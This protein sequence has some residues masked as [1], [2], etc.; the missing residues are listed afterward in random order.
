MSAEAVITT[1]GRGPDLVM[2]HGWAMNSNCWGELGER[3]SGSFRLHLVDLPGHGRSRDGGHWKLGPVVAQIRAQT[4]PA[5]WLGWSLGGFVA[6]RAALDFPSAVH[7]LILLSTNPCFVAS[8]EWPDAMPSSQFES[9]AGGL[10]DD[11]DATLQRFLALQVV[12]SEH[13][14]ETLRKARDV[15]AGFPRPA[16]PGLKSGLEILGSTNLLG[17]LDQLIQ[18]G[19]LIS[20]DCDRLVPLASVRRAALRMPDVSSF[21]VPGAGHLPFLSHPQAVLHAIDSFLG[22]REAA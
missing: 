11:T 5:I 16:L 4:P 15:Q 1:R 8:A 7:K 22:R 18:P 20:G 6:I 13:A 2:I 10:E 14:R 17:E 19:L 9:F 3:L 21:K 12:G